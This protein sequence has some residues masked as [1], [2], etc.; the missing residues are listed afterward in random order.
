MLLFGWHES[1]IIYNMGGINHRQYIIW[2]A[3]VT[4][5]CTVLLQEVNHTKAIQ[6]VDVHIS[7]VGQ[8]R[9]YTPYMTVYLVPCQNYRIYT[10]YIWFWPTLHIS[11]QREDES[12]PSAPHSFL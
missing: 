6:C 12:V 9:I 7:R 10:V 11:K 3:Q 1:Q 8:N 2:V 4:D 5:E